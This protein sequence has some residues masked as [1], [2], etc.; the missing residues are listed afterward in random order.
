MAI[1]RI[2]LIKSPRPTRNGKGEHD[3]AAPLSVHVW[4]VHQEGLETVV[5]SRQQG[6]PW[7]PERG[8]GKA[9]PTTRN[10]GFLENRQIPG[11]DLA[12]TAEERHYPRS[13]EPGSS[14]LRPSLNELP[15]ARDRTV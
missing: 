5:D 3:S 2:Q 11:L 6:Q 1:K 13:L 14:E 7:H 8:L 15:G 4:S 9:F 10:Q 12:I